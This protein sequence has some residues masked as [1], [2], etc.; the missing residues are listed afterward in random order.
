MA[1]LTSSLALS[2]LIIWLLL[3]KHHKVRTQK[4]RLPGAAN[5]ILF[6]SV[7]LSLGQR[8]GQE[9]GYLLGVRQRDESDL[10][11]TL[12]CTRP[13]LARSD[14]EHFCSTGAHGAK[15]V[16][17]VFALCLPWQAMQILKTEWKRHLS[18]INNPWPWP[19]SPSTCS[20]SWFGGL[21][22]CQALTLGMKR[23][24]GWCL[25][26]WW[27]PSPVSGACQMCGLQIIFIF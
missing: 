10:A 16:Q 21:Q 1:C 13:K 26:S 23:G 5:H 27:P 12:Y 18:G 7:E 25:W 14:L 11:W 19:P 9:R 15:P 22:A 3:S 20:P 8:N 4:W 24:P 17:I 6:D 2:E